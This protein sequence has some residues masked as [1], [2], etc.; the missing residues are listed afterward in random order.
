MKSSL[1][2]FSVITLACAVAHTGIARADDITIDPRPFVSSKSRSQVQAEL[3][4]Y[5]KSGVNPWALSYNPLKDFRSSKTR[6]AVTAEYLRERNAV[7]A[8]N[9]ED[10]GSRYLTELRD[11]ARAVR[12]ASQP[13]PAT[14]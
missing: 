9:G 2:R 13:A 1:L 7:A 6:A 8:M 12:Y 3:H 10:S 14:P 4:A 5:R 11:T